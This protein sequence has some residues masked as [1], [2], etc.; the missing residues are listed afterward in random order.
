M[1]RGFPLKG[2][3]ITAVAAARKVEV[4]SYFSAN[5]QVNAGEFSMQVEEVG[6]FYAAGGAEAEYSV[7]QGADPGWVRLYL[8]GQVAVALMHQR[9]MM[10]LHASSFVHNGKGVMILGES[11][12]GKSSLTASFAIGGAGLLTDDITPVVM[13]D[14]GPHIMALHE[15]I[16][17]RKNTAE[18]LNIDVSLLRDAESGTGKQYMKTGGGKVAH[19][20]LDVILRVEVGDVDAPVI[21][22]PLPAEKFS[23]L[24]SEICMSELLAGMAETETAYLHQLVRIIEEVPFARVVRPA[25]IRIAD[26]HSVVERF[27]DRLPGRG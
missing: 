11:G 23:F 21:E 3:K 27:L 22:E 15:S 20:P 17:I 2:V 12:A 13:K 6:S 5:W 4:P 25:G 7:L 26:L 9:G 8:N 18:Q 24:R 10:T 16:R 1:H 19:H 14:T